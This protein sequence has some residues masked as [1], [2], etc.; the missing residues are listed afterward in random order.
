MDHRVAADRFQEQNDA[1]ATT[2]KNLASSYAR[3]L[4]T[5]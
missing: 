2:V 1:S 4:V 3:K 5:V